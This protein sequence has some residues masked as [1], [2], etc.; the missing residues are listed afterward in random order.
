MQPAMRKMLTSTDT[1]MATSMEALVNQGA[2][3]AIRNRLITAPPR[4]LCME[5]YLHTGAMLLRCACATCQVTCDNHQRM[6]RRIHICSQPTR[7]CRCARV[8]SVLV[9]TLIT[10]CVP[11][12]GSLEQTDLQQ[13]QGH[14]RVCHLHLL[15]QLARTQATVKETAVKQTT[16]KQTTVK[17]TIVNQAS[18]RKVP[19]QS[20]LCP[21]STIAFVMSA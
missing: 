8:V 7:W 11:W 14:Q 1:T 2:Y 9:K 5:L 17:Q 6:S 12:P 21:I 3:R 15:Y 19:Q 13:H 16:V 4:M 20:Q 18:A 10:K